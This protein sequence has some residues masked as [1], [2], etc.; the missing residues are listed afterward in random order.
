MWVTVV[1]LAEGNCKGEGDIFALIATRMVTG[2][3]DLG[4]TTEGES[5]QVKRDLEKGVSRGTL[6]TILAA[7]L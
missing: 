7:Y 1:K 4:G 2:S 6:M 5:N 3:I